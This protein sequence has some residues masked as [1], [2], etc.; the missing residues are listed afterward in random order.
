MKRSKTIT[1]LLTAVITF[2]LC[3]PSRAM[4][5]DAGSL[6]QRRDQS[7]CTVGSTSGTTSAEAYYAAFDAIDRYY[8]AVNLSVL[9]KFVLFRN[10]DG[11]VSAGLSDEDIRKLQEVQREADAW[12]A[13]NL[14][15][16][17]PQ[18]TDAG[19]AILLCAVWIADHTSSDMENCL[20][21][22][23][24]TAIR[25][26][27]EGSGVCGGYA[28]AFNTMIRGLPV[29][30]ETRTIDYSGTAPVSHIGTKLIQNNIHAWSAIDYGDGWHYYDVCWFDTAGR[31]PRYLDMSSS[32]LED[33]SHTGVL[34]T[35]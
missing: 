1:L 11:T 26:F 19:A 34:T 33:A 29:N 17:I 9:E 30:P 35:W 22:R 28:S 12:I 13:G 32:L 25:V 18:G 16:I 3:F 7:G 27:Q 4:E 24:Q 15:A 14:P 8:P 23:N 2:I 5:S 20:D 6:F 10:P 21:R 31:D